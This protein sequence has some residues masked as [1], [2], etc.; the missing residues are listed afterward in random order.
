MTWGRHDFHGETVSD[1]LQDNEEYSAFVD[2]LK[3]A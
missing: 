3:T 2:A 1:F